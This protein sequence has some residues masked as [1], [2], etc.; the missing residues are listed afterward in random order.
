MCIAIF[1]GS[2][3]I[4][5]A[6][7]HLIAASGVPVYLTY[8]RQE[9]RAREACES[10]QSGGGR[11]AWGPC[12][13]LNRDSVS[14]AIATAASA[15]GALEGIVCASG[16][17]VAQR[18]LGEVT[19]AEFQTAIDSDVHGF[20]NLAQIALP[21]LRASGGTIVAVTTMAVYH[22]PLKNGLSAIPKSAVEMMCRTIAREEG[23]Y[24]IRANCVAPGFI[25]AGLGQQIMDENYSADV[26]D[27]QRQQVALRRFAQASEVG[28][29]VAFLSSRRSSY[30]TGQTI[31]VDGGFSL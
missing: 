24:G 5:S 18:Y 13:L 2:G 8:L 12:D 15:L 1:G 27:K 30:V 25:T 6:A 31:I 3:A 10:I 17:H 20:F 4:G 23:R 22:S 16:P 19:T 21:P 9:A 29:V 26:W 14:S 7:A 11:A 28:E